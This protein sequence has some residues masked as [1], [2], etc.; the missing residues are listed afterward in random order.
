MVVA[1]TPPGFTAQPVTAVELPLGSVKRLEF[2]VVEGFGGC[3][4]ALATTAIEACAGWP[5]TAGAGALD[6]DLRSLGM[7]EIQLLGE[8]VCPIGD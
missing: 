5:G 4:I 2:C 7:V 6:A 3:G 1:A 8:G